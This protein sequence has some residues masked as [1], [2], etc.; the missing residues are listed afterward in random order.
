LQGTTGSTRVGFVNKADRDNLFTLLTTKHRPAKQ[1]QQIA[2]QLQGV[3]NHQEAQPAT[4]SPDT[5][6]DINAVV[7]AG[8]GDS[9]S[10]VLNRLFVATGSANIL[11]LHD[12]TVNN[13]LF[14]K[15]EFGIMKLRKLAPDEA[16]YFQKKYD[17]LQ[18]QVNAPEYLEAMS[19]PSQEQPEINVKEQFQPGPAIVK[20]KTN[21]MQGPSDAT[22]KVQKINVGETVE[23]LDIQYDC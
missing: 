8:D 6:R 2:T 16:D 4:N 14:D 9:I 1:A 17:A 18:E 5:I 21:V 22:Q 13:A 20:T 23:A 10:N 12:A 15:L 19:Q 11:S 3:G 7:F